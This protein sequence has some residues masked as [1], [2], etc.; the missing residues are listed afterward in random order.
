MTI[1]EIIIKAIK[2][3]VG[4]GDH[5]TLATTDKNLTG[6]MQLIVKEKGVIAGIDLAQKILNIHD[7]EIIMKRFLSDGDIVK[8]GDIAFQ[9]EGKVSS[10]LSIERTMLNFM[11]RMSG[12]ATYT[13]FL[14]KKIEC[15]KTKLLDTRKTTPLL[16]L[17]EKEAVRIGGGYNH[18]FG[19]YDM[20]MIKDNHIDFA[21]GIKNAL[22]MTH[23]Y[24]K[25]KNLNLE[26]VIEVRNLDDIM[27]VLEVGKVK[28]ILLDNFDPKTL[29]KAVK[30]IN[31]KLETEASGNINE[32]N[33]V[34]YAKT[35][36][37]YISIGALTHHVR[38]L[39]LSLKVAKKFV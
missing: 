3:D 37:D 39:D 9:I 22:L 20:I 2:E 29:A 38:S 19:L 1:K 17:I 6:K 15:F 24:L 34:E 4:D 11:Q 13:R 16:R 21:G 32:S 36:V 7:T 18:R 28:R 26:I 33:I 8:A 23:N 12:I 14:A 10:L 35:G 27:K 25:T 30:I 31:N 5:T